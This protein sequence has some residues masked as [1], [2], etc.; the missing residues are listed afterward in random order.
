MRP[1]ERE[2]AR[3]IETTTFLFPRS[4]K[5]LGHGKD[6]DEEDPSLM[7]GLQAH[8]LLS[9]AC[10]DKDLRVLLRWASNPFP[11]LVSFVVKHMEREG[12]GLTGL[13][14]YP[15]PSTIVNIKFSRNQEE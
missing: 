1:L 11:G 5:E 14:A 3:E 12:V 2:R 9:L 15:A 8:S 7:K 13:S 10:L 6:N 4:H